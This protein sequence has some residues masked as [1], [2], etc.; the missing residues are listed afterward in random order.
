MTAKNV[1]S[2]TS[3]GL[4]R[5]IEDLRKR[6]REENIGVLYVDENEGFVGESN[7]LCAF[8]GCYGIIVRKVQ[9]DIYEVTE[10]AF[11]S[12]DTIQLFNEEKAI[13]LARSLASDFIEDRL[14]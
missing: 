9:H 8:E 4:N 1:E 6:L 14:T 11:M 7:F 5:A 2:F 3:A 12:A 13:D 10:R